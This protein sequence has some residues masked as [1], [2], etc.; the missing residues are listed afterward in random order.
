M[1]ERAVATA[2]VSTSTTMARPTAP[3]WHV[4]DGKPS[5]GAL[6]MLCV[7][8][9]VAIGAGGTLLRTIQNVDPQQGRRTVRAGADH[10]VE[11]RAPVD[12]RTG[13]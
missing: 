3:I 1:L 12:L 4:S 6:T 2:S 11:L 9:A 13:L 5:T 8:S 7:A 10:I